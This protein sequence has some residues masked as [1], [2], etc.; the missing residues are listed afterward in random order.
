MEGEELW[1]SDLFEGISAG[2][3]VVSGNGEY[4][5]VT[6]N[7]DQGTV[8]H[9]SILDGLSGSLF[10]SQENEDAPFAPPGIHHA[11]EEGYY[12]GGENNRNDILVWSVQPKPDDDVVGSGGQFAFQFPI[13]FAGVPDGIGYIQ[14]GN[15]NRDFQTI[16]KPVFT[17]G[18]RS[19]Y[20]GTTRSQF[21]CWIGEEGKNRYRFNRPRTATLGFSRGKPP[22]Q[23]VYAPL[24]LTNSQEELFLFGGTASTEFV[25]LNAN[26]TEELLITTTGLVKTEARISPD[27]R[28]VYYVEFNG[29]LHQASTEDLMD[30]W[31][32]D[33][34]VPV[35]GESALRKDGT[36]LYIADVTG[37][38][39]ALRVAEH[40]SE[41]PSSPPTKA[42][43]ATL[44]ALPTNIA[45]NT[46]TRAPTAAPTANPISSDKPINVE[47]IK[48]LTS[49]DPGSSGAP[50]EAARSAA[51]F[52]LVVL[53]AAFAM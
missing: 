12:E 17:N 23:S 21:R 46:P 22:S 10:L 25:K 48:D 30:S 6:H 14:L 53:L 27:D 13:G 4:V 35:E 32:Y 1:V 41:A 50:S 43:T 15:D 16:Q 28:Y 34:R 36:I 26:F 40:L 24:A 11:P 20:W 39:H 31:V 49:N 51:G 29:Y 5:F 45:S 3:P 38:I 52:F 18:G 33:I 2:T 9:F 8:G 7:S 37:S 44:T 42:P 19:L 47:P